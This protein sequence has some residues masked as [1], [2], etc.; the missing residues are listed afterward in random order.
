MT[1][2]QQRPD[3]EA[4]GQQGDFLTTSQGARLRDT[5]HS[6]KAGARGPVLLQDHHLREK[7]THFDHERIPERVVHARGA[8]AHGVFQSYGTAE[9]VTSAAFLR[10]GAITPTFTRFST[11]LGSRGSADTV[12]D[13]R[14]F[15]TKFYTEE[16]TFDLVGNNIPVFF[17]QD[18]IKFPD[19]IHAAKPHPDREIPQAQSAHDTFW[20]FVSLHPEAQHHTLWN[21]SDRGI[22]RSYRMMEGFGIHTF[23]L[24]GQDGRT[25]L[26]KWH[27][28]PRL[29]VHSLT[30]EEAQ[31]VSGID[32]DFH[33]RDLADAIDAGSFPQWELGIQV[34]PDNEE[35]SFEGIDLLDPTK[36]VPEELAPVQLVGR[37]TLNR[38]PRNYF[39]ETEQVAFHPGN[40]P[41]GI[42]VTD[43]PLLQVRLFSY[44]DTQL[45]RLGGPNWNQLPINRPHAPVDDMLRDGYGQQDIHQGIAPYRPNSLGGGCPFTAGDADRPFTDA[46][47]HIPETVKNRE[48]SA[49]FADHYSQARLFWTSMTPV[50]RQHI[51]GAYSF[52]L[53]KCRVP[54][55]R[56]R[57]L[58]CLARIDAD[59]CQQVA[60]ALGEDAP[61][62]DQP[63]AEVTPS[64]ALSQLGSRWPVDG[65]M[66]GLVV[67]SDQ[68]RAEL[69]AV[70]GWIDE[71]SMTPVLVAPHGGS[72]AG[73]PV[74]E[75]F[76]T[77]RSVQ[78]DALLLASDPV[79]TPDPDQKADAPAPFGHDPRITLMVEECWRH[80]KAIG[81]WGQ[82]RRV[83]DEAV[84]A[85]P[86]VV[87]DQQPPAVLS[88]VTELLAAHRVWERFTPELPA[89]GSTDPTARP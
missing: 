35:Q 24:I 36:F 25:S 83:L 72:V 86:G 33:R 10:K 62:P 22:P 71:H 67:G 5:D 14:G 31:M 26:V 21:M 32:P 29:G 66:I 74:D 65:R 4:P 39:A 68:D 81:A 19:I 49:S 77:A 30:W 15:A 61:A 89:T 11:V 1:S 44:Q 54:E 52:E 78:F 34:F 82:G 79:A 28:K 55:V 18:G 70:L 8:A 17:I 75:T 84:E 6:L 41:P 51:V 43:D 53:S 42:D 57:Q 2:D 58:E 13:T 37:L 76:A 56:R 45:T 69:D 48:L 88:A 85:G 20:D 87:E 3:P 60:D 7:I 9:E 80:A 46:P 47:V 40:L 50:E 59:L 23:R 38:N 27:W 73:H 12:R 16:G 64:P 63:L